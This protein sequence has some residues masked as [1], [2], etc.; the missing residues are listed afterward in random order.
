[1]QAYARL[2]TADQRLVIGDIAVVDTEG[3]LLAEIEGFRAQ[4]LE[5]SLSLAPER[6]DRSLYELEWRPTERSEDAAAVAPEEGSWLIFTDQSGV[7]E[8]LTRLLE[9]RGE[10]YVTVSHA[11]TPEL[12]EQGGHYALNPAEPEHFR[13]LFEALSAR[14][15]TSF[16]RVVQLWSLDSTFSETSPLAELEREQ[17]L[18]A[19][20]I[21]YLIQTLAQTGWP[22]LPRLWL[23][24][25]GAQA[26]G[27][28]RRPLA[29]AQAPVWGLGR[30]IGHQ[31][32]TSLWGG[33]LDLD[34]APAAE[35]ASLLFDELWQSDGEDQ[36]AFRDGQRYVVR[37]VPS[38]QLTP[39]LPASFRP[40]GSYLLTGGL[41]A[42]GLLVARWMVKQGARRLILMGRTQ[43]PPRSTWHELEA[44]HRQSGVIQAIQELEGLGA[45]IHLAAV[46]VAEE[47]QLSG[48][49]AQ[50]EREG[51]PAIRGVIHTAG[52]VQDELL[53]RMKT[54]T[55]QRVLRPKVSGGWLL[56]R[57]LKDRPLDF[58]VLFSSTGS[59]IASLGQGNY[60][61]GNAFLDALAQ[62]RRAQGLPGL[63]IG[64]GPWSVGMV[65]QLKLEQY[66]AKRGI[67]LITPEVGMQ[68]LGRVLGQRPVHLTAISANWA[69]AR[70]TSPV[71]VLPPMFSLLG[72]QA[73]EAATS[74]TNNEDGALLEQLRAVEAAERQG[75]VATHLQELI[76]RVMQLD[77]SQ[78]SGQETL[79]SLGMD[80]MMAIEVKRRLEGTL[81][82]EVSVLE[83]LQGVTVVQLA[84][85]ILAALQFEERPEA[86]EAVE[87]VAPLADIEQLIE[88]ADS[89]ELERLLAELELTLENEEA[90]A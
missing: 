63:S 5:A 62:H 33:L 81:K 34:D 40:D 73:Q 56:H 51:W 12:R 27:A 85:R 46:D 8:A 74:E 84:A 13:Q 50:Y 78:F 28:E 25:R 86:A 18:G 59:V 77:P 37:L 60:A 90:V 53:L 65:E 1:M 54:E 58:F 61:A 79:T 82:V 41:G 20:A 3:N 29:V 36:V 67:E 57:L 75:M 16:S 42:L 11:D 31:E 19:Q 10:R 22:R 68:M 14:E 52:V 2:R 70:E 66:Y 23:V 83:L 44:E 88:Q 87:A 7:G 64:W 69:V 38:G 9:Q 89:G 21:V 71:G 30:V 48:F 72:E 17:T 24:T 76:A 47:G 26:V 39:P 6:I 15:Q 32:F 45:T 43:L 49:L 80:S 55:F 4:S 35:Q